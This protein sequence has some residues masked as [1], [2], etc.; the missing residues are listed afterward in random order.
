MTECWSVT[1]NCDVSRTIGP[2]Q[3]IVTVFEC[4]DWSTARRQWGGNQCVCYGSIRGEWEC[5][6][7]IESWNL[8]Q[9]VALIPDTRFCARRFVTCKLTEPQSASPFMLP[10]RGLCHEFSALWKPLWFWNRVREYAKGFG[11][12]FYVVKWLETFCFFVFL[13]RL[14]S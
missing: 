2:L 5:N 1:G 12:T 4:I 9:I 8:M 3:C 6:G 7:L 11:A 10:T 13:W 14:K